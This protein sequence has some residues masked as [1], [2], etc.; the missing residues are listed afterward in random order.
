MSHDPADITRQATLRY[1]PSAAVDDERSSVAS[2]AVDHASNR[3]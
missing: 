2:T 1:L 3:H